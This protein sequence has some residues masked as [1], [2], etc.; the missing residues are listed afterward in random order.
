M[1]HIKGNPVKAAPDLGL[2]GLELL[3]K[4][5]EIIEAHPEHWDQ[6]S[7]AKI[8]DVPD[9]A[10][11][12]NWEHDGDTV[13]ESCGTAMCVAGW[14]AHLC[15][16]QMSWD[17]GLDYAFRMN[18]LHA[19]RIVIRDSDRVGPSFM[20]IPDFAQK[21]LGLNGEE[22]AELFKPTNNLATIK[23]LRNEFARRLKRFER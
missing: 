7:W 22:A 10:V 5:I 3:D 2:R 8:T 1:P 19:V 14:A 21:R 9:L 12:W 17:L 4:I 6:R 15:G 11:G 18:T 16:A 23:E 13:P 20:T